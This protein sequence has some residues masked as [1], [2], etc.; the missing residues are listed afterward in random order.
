MPAQS[1]SVYDSVA[2]LPSAF[3]GRPR[4]SFTYGADFLT[5]PASSSVSQ[6]V[7]INDD[8][9][10]V[11]VFQSAILTSDSA[12]STFVA[13]LPLT[14]LLTDSGSGRNDM[15]KP[16]HINNMF[17][18]SPDFPFVLAQPRIL[19]RSSTYTVTLANLTSTATYTARLSF[20][21]YKMYGDP[22]LNAGLS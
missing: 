17:G 13:N 7:T 10:F 6:D 22:V 9:D 12:Q 8:A 11:I 5:I 14:V 15:N 2:L 4:Q 3:Q 1:Y 21:G 18:V 20:V 19:L 16:Q